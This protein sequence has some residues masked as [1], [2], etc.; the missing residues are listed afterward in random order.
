M[1]RS[2]GRGLTPSEVS[3][4]RLLDWIYD[5]TAGDYAS[6]IPSVRGFADK[7]EL[8]PDSVD[9]E[10]RALERRGLLRFG[11]A[12]LGGVG[13]VYLTDEGRRD[14]EE[15]KRRREE[16]GLRRRACRDAF[17]DWLDSQ[18]GSSTNT[19]PVDGFLRD[20]RSTW[21]GEPFD[22]PDVEVATAYLR[23]RGLVSGVEVEE[24]GGPIRASITAAGVDCVEAG[25]SV[26]DYLNRGQ[27]A[28]TTITTHFHGPVPGQV[29][30]GNTIHQTQYQGL[31]VETL[32][33]LLLDVREAAEQVDPGEAQ[34]LL[35][36][37]DTIQ[38][39]VTAESPNSAVIIGSGERL[40]QIATKAGDV[41]L[42]AS[43]TALV[44]FLLR[45]FGG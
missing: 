34:Y 35:T 32:N 28:G 12:R 17:L 3:H 44:N 36:Y 41:G 30:I 45:A 40:K 9:H 7:E 27:L 5:E 23:D 22:V 39:E 42:V 24:F 10:A 15:R 29:G 43:V 37:A 25:G 21:E 20:N 1:S 2:Q 33:R 4:I 19:V 16:P 38:A 14:V 31:D 8:P 26:A 18:P 13:T 11:P 6:G